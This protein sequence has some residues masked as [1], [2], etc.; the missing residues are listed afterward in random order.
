M[1]KNYIVVNDCIFNENLVDQEKII[2][3]A[4][5]AQP[6]LL[7]CFG[8]FGWEQKAPYSHRWGFSYPGG[9]KDVI[10]AISWCPEGF[11]TIHW[12]YVSPDGEKVEMPSK[13]VK[14]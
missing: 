8:S 11:W 10:E 9:S 5:G 6:E 1:K 7:E 12:I 2:R 14:A 3:S 4:F 13:Y